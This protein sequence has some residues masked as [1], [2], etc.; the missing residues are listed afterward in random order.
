MNW[1]RARAVARKEFLHIL[2]DR[3][4]LALALLLPFVMLLLFGYAL[5]LDVDRIPTVIYDQ[6]KTPESRNLIRQF[7]GSRFFEVIDAAEN[8]ARIDRD[9]DKSR[10]LLA[11]VI[12]TT[13][14]SD[15]L[16]G[17]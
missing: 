17:R 7:S 2:R 4:S 13:Y 15:L 9:I 1:R 3:R 11:L 12:P 8:Y 10:A 6:D 5:S 16:S 14:S